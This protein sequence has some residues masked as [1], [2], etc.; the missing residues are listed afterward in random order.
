MS[1]PRNSSMGRATPRRTCGVR[2]APTARQRIA[3]GAHVASSLVGK[4]GTSVTAVRVCRGVGSGGADAHW[5]G[6]GSS[7]VR[8]DAAPERHT[9]HRE[10]LMIG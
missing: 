3:G 9:V 6:P 5:A 8:V 7:Y 2:Y 1:P 10:W 4:R